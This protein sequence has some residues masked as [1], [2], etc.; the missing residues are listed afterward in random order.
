MNEACVI[1]ISLMYANVKAFTI[2]HL[3]VITTVSLKVRKRT[4][5]LNSKGK[6]ILNKKIRQAKAHFLMNGNNINT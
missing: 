4:S 1:S 3:H 6:R 2:T 5:L